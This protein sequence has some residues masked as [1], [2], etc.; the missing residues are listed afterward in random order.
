MQKRKFTLKSIKSFFAQMG[1]AI[2]NW[3]NN[4]TSE[5]GRLLKEYNRRFK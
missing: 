4:P 1:K 3:A 2:K 5:D